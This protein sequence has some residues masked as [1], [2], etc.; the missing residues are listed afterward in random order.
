MVRRFLK[1]PFVLL[2]TLML[3]AVL[4]GPLSAAIEPL[5]DAFRSFDAV[6]SSETPTGPSDIDRPYNTDVGSLLGVTFDVAQTQDGTLVFDGEQGEFGGEVTIWVGGS[7]HPVTAVEYVDSGGVP[8][9]VVQW[10][11]GAREDRAELPNGVTLPVQVTED[12]V[13]KEFVLPTF[14]DTVQVTEDWVGKEFVLPTFIDTVQVT[15]DWVGK[16]IS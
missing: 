7:Q 1:A 9:P 2:S 5:F 11:L 13:G 14:I 3:L 8:R 12:W 10:H 6:Q 16:T 15:E 4:F